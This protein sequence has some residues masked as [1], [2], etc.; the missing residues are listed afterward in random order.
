MT[1]DILTIAHRWFDEVWNTRRAETID[2]LLTADS[3]CHTDD[4]LVRG[5]DE[6]R[7]RM[8]GPLLAAFPDLR[9]TL[10]HTLV[11]GAFV[12]VRWTATATHTGTGFGVEPTGRA[13]TFRGITWLR[14]ADGKLLEGWQHTNIPETIR[15]LVG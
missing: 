11:E 4:G 8:Y 10:D 6:F 2:E 14:I 7:S 1:P 3:V 5:P 15:A 12:V 13:V 9:V